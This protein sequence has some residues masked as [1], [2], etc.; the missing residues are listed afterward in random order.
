MVPHRGREALGPLGT[1]FAIGRWLPADGIAPSQHLLL[2]RSVVVAPVYQGPRPKPLKHAAS[3]AKLVIDRVPG[4]QVRPV[5]LNEILQKLASGTASLVHFVCHGGAG[6]SF[7]VQV[8][9]L[10]SGQLSSLQVSGM[11]DLRAAFSS[12]PLIFLNACEVGRLTSALVGVGGFAKAF[13]DLGAGAVIAP[14]WNVK[15]AIAHDVAQEFYK[16]LEDGAAVLPA[17]VFRDVRRK[18]YDGATA[19]EDTF[20]AYCFF[21]DPLAVAELRTRDE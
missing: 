18:A 16:R 10:E 13:I 14:L 12:K 6:N 15:D 21:G 7:G 1:Q 5:T 9:E 8:I 3:E 20:A 4:E 17:E 19:G 2:S 11:D